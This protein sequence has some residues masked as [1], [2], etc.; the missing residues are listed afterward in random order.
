MKDT[1]VIFGSFDDGVM[2]DSFQWNRQDADL[3]V[4]NE[5]L[6][7]NV[8]V[9][10]ATGVIQMH[11][12]SV[13]RN[14]LN[15]ND[16]GHYDWLKANDAIPVYMHEHFDEIPMSVKYPFDEIVATLLPNWERDKNEIWDDRGGYFTSTPAYAIA[17]GIYQGY[18][19]IELWGFGLAV[20]TEY[21]YQR[22]GVMFWTG[23]ALGH[24]VN[25][26]VKGHMFDAPL[27]GYQGDE[28]ITLD[29]LEKHVEQLE[30]K[31]P[32]YKAALKAAQDAADIA[33]RA[34][35]DR[36]VSDK[37]FTD[38][39]LN[40]AKAQVNYTQH[41]AYLLENKQHITHAHEMSAASGENDYRLPRSVFELR[42]NY[43]ISEYGKADQDR[44]LTRLQVEQ[45]FARISKAGKASGAGVDVLLGAHAQRCRAIDDYMQI[46][47]ADLKQVV[48]LVAYE[49]QAKECARYMG[50]FDEQYRAAGK[51]P[52]SDTAGGPKEQL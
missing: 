19:R 23:Y 29:L 7:K 51:A 24:G 2:R 36:K 14:P 48:M 22:P 17:L 35:K 34:Y 41:E 44:S 16:K 38:A 21:V 47:Q 28:Y 13:W 52:H 6:S 15:R 12:P 8:W 43:F 26:V 1:L 11:L 40:V 39:M 45:S 10:W 30:A 42:R 4:F 49:S 37:T 25:L 3:W 18:K 31:L 9:Q 50:I 46:Y 5:G 33:I 27:Y 32:E 20:N